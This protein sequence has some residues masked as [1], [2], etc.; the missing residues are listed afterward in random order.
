MYSPHIRTAVCAIAKNESMYIEEWVAYYQL[1][2]FDEILIYSNDS[3]DGSQATLDAMQT[4]GLIVYRD[5]P[6]VPGA[7]PQLTAYRDA[8]GRT[9]AEWILFVDIDE[10]LNLKSDTVVS[11]FLNRFAPD[12]GAVAI[13]WKVFGTSGN[14]Y[15]EDELITTRFD[16]AAARDYHVNR[17]CKTFSKV[18]CTGDVHIHR[19]FLKSGAYVDT[20][21]RPIE[22]ERNGFTRSVVHAVAQVNHYVLK[23]NQEFQQKRERGNANRPPESTDKYAGRIGTYFADHD[24]NETIDRDLTVF[25]GAIR[26]R[27]DRNRRATRRHPIEAT[28]Y[29]SFEDREPAFVHR[30][31]VDVAGTSRRLRVDTL[32]L[33]EDGVARHV[34]G[35]PA[36]FNHV[37]I[38]ENDLA[39]WVEKRA[40][41]RSGES[42]LAPFPVARPAILFL[43]YGYLNF[44]RLLIGMIPRA[45]LAR[46]SYPD[47]V[48]VV[49]Q[50]M[51]RHL[52]AKWGDLFFDMLRYFGLER[53]LMVL[54]GEEQ[55]LAQAIFCASKASCIAEALHPMRR[56]ALERPPSGEPARRVFISRSLATARRIVNEDQVTA[57]LTEAGFV[58]VAMER[59]PFEEQVALFRQADV[60]VAPH[61]S[62]L[63]HTVFTKRG[64]VVVELMPQKA[65]YRTKMYGEL[66]ALSGAVHHVVGCEEAGDEG[67]S[68]PNRDMRVDVGVLKALLQT[69]QI[70]EAPAQETP[71]AAAVLASPEPAPP[72]PVAA[73]SAGAGAAASA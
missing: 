40:A 41:G 39:R 70:V 61:G 57:L 22:I 10:F 68:P 8:L 35:A 1:L 42:A 66:A 71:A 11:D 34:G 9:S 31:P 15:F 55:V 30:Y 14:A 52:E 69:L 58:T 3:T 37:A 28:T 23:S 67:L 47:A 44:Y 49:R 20:L 46:E 16:R 59:I 73:A 64:A 60:I 36:S 12:V 29:E 51:L 6:S 56:C 38:S 26:D 5:W 50:D 7:S 62:A 65:R 4:Q 43:S 17:H 53:S 63:A 33:D 32:R 19:S 54:P 48:V 72:P 13:N 45:I 18:V 27:I 24:R 25:R 21:G 2:G